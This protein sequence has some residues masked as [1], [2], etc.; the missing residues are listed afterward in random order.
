MIKALVLKELREIRG[1]AIIAV[2]GYALFL[3]NLV[4]IKLFLEVTAESEVPFVYP[5]FLVFFA[6]VTVP[7]AIAL[8]FRQAIGEAVRGTFLFLLHRPIDRDWIFGVKLATGAGLVL[9]VG[10]VPLLGFIWWSSVPG[11]HAG[12]FEW[13]MTGDSWR[14]LFL[15]PLLYLGAFLS[16]M[17]PAKWYGTRVLPLVASSALVTWLCLASWRWQLLLPV[18][19]VC[20]ITF[21]AQVRYVTSVRD[22]A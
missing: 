7:F 20:Y 22:Y 3:S 19:A 18:A 16:G 6:I 2:A 15:A 8:G 17:R 9:L 21:L 5:E 4:G 1:I 14:F 13:S 10:G 11:H 12:P